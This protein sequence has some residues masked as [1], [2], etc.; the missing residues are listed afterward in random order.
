MKVKIYKKQY[1]FEEVIETM[2]LESQWCIH[3]G[4]CEYSVTSQ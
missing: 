2:Y 1:T 4:S 3:N